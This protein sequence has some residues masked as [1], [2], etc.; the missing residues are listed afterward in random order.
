VILGSPLPLRE[1]EPHA[2][3]PLITNHIIDTPRC[4]V[5]VG[6]G[7]GKSV[8]TLTALD[9]LFLA[10]ESHP[11]LIVGPLRVARRT[12]PNDA[13]KWKHLRHVSVLP[14]VGSEEERRLA[15]KY[16]AS[17]FTV[18]YENLEW[19]VQHWGDRWPYQH[20]GVG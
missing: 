10:G 18:N 7:M 5:W 19:L 13:R 4:A 20:R 15:M 8:A 1:Y 2:Y 12:W 9:M 6:M 16:D 3:Q 17:V 14:I 11:A